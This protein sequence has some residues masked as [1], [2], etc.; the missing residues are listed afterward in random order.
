MKI[1]KLKPAFSEDI[2][3]SRSGFR[4]IS[5]QFTIKSGLKQVRKNLFD[6]MRESWDE[7]PASGDRHK[8]IK[9]RGREGVRGRMGEWETRS[10]TTQFRGAERGEGGENVLFMICGGIN[11]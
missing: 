9:V 1:T 6:L 7:S 4:E 8:L 10:E 11:N 5:T 3:S 2:F